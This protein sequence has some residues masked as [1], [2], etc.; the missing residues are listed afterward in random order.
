MMSEMQL[1]P[2][3][4][5]MLSQWEPSDRTGTS[6]FSGLENKMHTVRLM[7]GGHWLESDAHMYFEHQR[8]ILDEARRRFG[9]LKI[10]VDVR[11]WVV[12]G[13]DSATV[14]QDMNRELYKADDRLVAVVKSFSYKRHARTALCAGKLEVFVSIN[15]AEAWLHA[16]SSPPPGY[17]PFN[18]MQ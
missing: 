1:S 10:F 4:L 13:P 18:S 12:E 2:S 9:P 6:F 8:K 7:G 5:D 11:D 15:A 17:A 16:C 3:S 14:F